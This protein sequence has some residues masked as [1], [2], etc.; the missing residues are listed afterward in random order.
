MFV[1][2]VRRSVSLSGCFCVNCGIAAA[3][4]FETRTAK[5]EEVVNKKRRGHAI[6]NPNNK[7]E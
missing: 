4:V 5:E 7:S 3:Q 1:S 6:F 2:S